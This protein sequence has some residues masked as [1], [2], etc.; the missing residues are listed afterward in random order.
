M[1]IKNLIEENHVVKIYQS[2][3]GEFCISPERNLYNALRTKYYSIAEE[4]AEKFNQTWDGYENCA[5][6]IQGINSDFNECLMLAISEVKNDLISMNIYEMDEKAILAQAENEGALEDYSKAY[7]IFAE[8][9]REI[10]GELNSKVAY[11]EMRKENRGQWQGGSI[12]MGESEGWADSYM[13]DAELQL[14]LGARNLAEGIGHSIFNSVGNM[15]STSNANKK[16]ETVFR[17]ENIKTSFK[18]GVF[19]SAWKLHLVLISLLEKQEMWDKPSQGDA[20]KSERLLNNID[21]GILTESERKNMIFEAFQLNPYDERFYMKMLSLYNDD[22]EIITE[23]AKYFNVNLVPQKDIL[24]LEYLK[25]NL[26]STEED[27]R[28]AKEKLLQFYQEIKLELTEEL[29]S[30]KFIQ[31]VL[32][33]FDLEYR[34][35]DAIVCT[36]R[37][38]ADYARIELPDILKFMEDVKEPGKDDLLDYER[39]LLSKKERF[40]EL[41][42]SELKEK[43][44]L[45]IDKYLQDFEKN[46]CN[47]GFLKTAN[48]KEAGRSRAN[49][50]IKTLD[51]ST[52]ENVA[53]AKEKLKQFLPFIGLTEEEAHEAFS[54][55][56]KNRDKLVN[57][58]SGQKIINKFGG[59]FKK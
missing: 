42:Q 34:T 33:D 6:M 23:I 4:V 13:N 8:K 30:Y 52:Q 53:V 26:G 40:M 54:G 15:I 58:T 1:I 7:E 10:E 3:I 27:A 35:V 46:F 19:A 24:A 43:Y 44:L 51:V 17:D 47:V 2:S 31:K 20:A 56:D 25:D 59:L 57:P 39:E 49:K 9:I 5:T 29:E 45:V 48:R 37:E 28:G 22:V 14:E 12:H 11:R 32:E 41:F 50:F 55:I 36:T 38:A 16:M 21:N 18:E